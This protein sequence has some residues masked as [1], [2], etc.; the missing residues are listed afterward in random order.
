[1]KVKKI[2][3]TIEK[4]AQLRKHKWFATLLFLIMAVIY[5]ICE[6]LFKHDNWSGYVKAFS[7]AAMVGALADW[8]AV[9]AL[10]RHPLGIPIPHT[11]L[12][13]SSKKKIGNNLGNFVTD[14]FLT[15][16]A[17]RPRL[18]HLEIA[19]RLGQ[20][21]LHDK[22]RKRTVS[23][24][25][26]IAR[27]ALTRMDDE[28]ITRMISSQANGL[29]EKMNV[30]KI[31]G[32]GLAKIVHDNMHQDWITTLTHYLG[33][34]LSE[35]RDLVKQKVKQE[36]HFLIPGFVDNLIAEKITNGGIRY[37]REIESN[38]HHPVRIKIGEKLADIAQDIQAG[39]GWA[40]RLE[41]LKNE[42]LSPAHLAE[43]SATIW[44]YTRKKIMDDLSDPDS[45]IGN[46]TDKMLKDAGLSLST[47]KAR[48][49]RIDQFVRLQAFKLIMKYKK[50][51]GEMISNTVTN[52]P[53]RQLSEKLE[54]EVGKDLQFIR[55]N[56][57]IVGGTVGLL[58]YVITKLFN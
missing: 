47:D 35:N 49:E 17:I 42:L 51:A 18:A 7:E 57:T 53:S 20:W 2:D 16:S 21:L 10:F 24:L 52:W 41:N 8:F 12:I 13:E 34:F 23:E 22:N 25:M 11:D 30:H 5:C 4:K 19:E 54:L 58:I 50:T 32:E 9:V 31:A 40:T 28:D 14:N 36:S 48:Q 26:R 33:N 45:G 43:Y 44:Q 46:Y 56:G 38:D 27:E 29:V 37:M 55:I 39:G 1:M 6:F 3:N 15:P